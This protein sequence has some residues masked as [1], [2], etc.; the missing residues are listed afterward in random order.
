MSLLQQL[1]AIA[2]HVGWRCRLSE[3]GQYCVAT[4]ALFGGFEQLASAFRRVE[5]AALLMAYLDGAAQAPGRALQDRRRYLSAPDIQ[6]M[7]GDGGA[8]LNEL[9]QRSVLTGGFV[10]KCP[11]CRSTAC[12]RPGETDPV[13]SC[14]RCRA[15]HRIDGSS[16][17][18][19][20]QPAWRYQLDEAVFQ[21][22]RHRGDLTVL[23]VHKC[24]SSARTVPGA[25]PEV[26]FV[27]PQ[28]IKSEIDFVVAIGGDL[29][30]GEGFTGDRYA[31]SAKREKERLRHLVATADLLNARGILLATATENLSA[32]SVR[33][34][35]GAVPGPWPVL[36]V[37]SRCELLNRPARLIDAPSSGAENARD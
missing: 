29:W 31:K 21:F 10:L 17:I 20:P 37:V 33:H 22:L 36:Q 25:V 4:A 1:E 19:H 3:K 28:G 12:Y 11:R 24:F 30:A 35:E 18:E 34:A 14:R 32:A 9:T 8:L 6:A 13:F 23:A 27:D 15:E 2:E 16:R 26:E 7:A 5:L